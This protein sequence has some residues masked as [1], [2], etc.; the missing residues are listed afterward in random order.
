M[1]NKKMQRSCSDTL[2][3][4]MAMSRKNGGK[5]NHIDHQDEAQVV[6]H[7]AQACSYTILTHGR[8]LN[9]GKAGGDRKS[10][11]S[12]QFKDRVENTSSPKS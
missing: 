12:R 7:S 8:Q 4:A 2:H 1:S 9:S 3:G 10:S 5:P 11:L 6:N